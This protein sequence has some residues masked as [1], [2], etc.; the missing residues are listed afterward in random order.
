[1]SRPK[2]NY[3][4]KFSLTGNLISTINPP[5]GAFAALIVPPCK[6]TARA[7]M[8]RWLHRVSVNNVLMY[9]RKKTRRRELMTQDGDAPEPTFEI[10]TRLR[11]TP[12]L[13][14]LALEGAIAQ[15]PPGYRA[16]FIL[17]DIEGYEHAEIARICGCS[18]G[19]SKS[20][21]HQARKKLYELLNGAKRP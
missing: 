9:F 21:L 6:R 12:V 7:A 3:R 19:T 2:Y 17:H 8:M 15:L 1:M 11:Q 18:T 14:K 13:D 20:Q 4:I 5:S 10:T 16:S